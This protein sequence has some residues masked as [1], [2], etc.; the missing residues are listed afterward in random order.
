VRVRPRKHKKTGALCWSGRAAGA[1][2]VSHWAAPEDTTGPGPTPTREGRTR[3]LLR[4]TAGRLRGGGCAEEGGHTLTTLRVALRALVA[5][6]DCW[7]RAGRGSPRE[8]CTRLEDK[9]A[10]GPTV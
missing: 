7:T 6:T 5:G 9:L 10:L 3:A 2:R 4:A 1:R 8:A